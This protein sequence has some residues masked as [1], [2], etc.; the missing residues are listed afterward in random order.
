[1]A[2]IAFFATLLVLFFGGRYVTRSMRKIRLTPN[3][4]PYEVVRA[5]YENAL[6]CVVYWKKIAALFK[7][8]MRRM[9]KERALV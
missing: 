5:L 4:D 6:E 8:E 7:K 1:M 3:E 2:P 9:E